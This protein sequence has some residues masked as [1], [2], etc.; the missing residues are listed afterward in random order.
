MNAELVSR[1]LIDENTV[2]IGDGFW[3]NGLQGK[4]ARL[5]SVCHGSYIGTAAEHEK[6][7]F[8]EPHVAEWGLIQEE[9][10]KDERVEVVSVS[11]RA[12]Q[13]LETM[14]DITVDAIIQH[15]LPLDIYLPNNHANRRL[16]LHVAT[17]S[18]KGND[19]LPLLS[20]RFK[21][22]Q[23]GFAQTGIIKEEAELWQRGG[24]FFMP[25]HY[26]G[27]SYALLEAMACGLVPVTYATGQ[28]CDLP[29]GAGEVT[30]DYH[31]HNFIMM[32]ERVQEYYSQYFPRE[33]AWENADF[34][35]FRRGWRKYLGV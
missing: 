33:W 27:A 19:M 3:V 4:V 8:G 17:S 25:T 21:M 24:I 16:I 22:E 29:C 35:T 30:D 11:K 10:W 32:L 15:G 26:E 34:G 12:A 2:V 23:L 31:E 1:K 20:D 13:E 28:A 18:R 7:P 6:H 9:I 14:C 5:I